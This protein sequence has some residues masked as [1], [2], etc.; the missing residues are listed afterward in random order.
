MIRSQYIKLVDTGSFPGGIHPVQHK[1]ESNSSPIATLPVPTTLW[2]P[3]AMHLG[4]P[5]EPIVQIGDRVF[6]GELIAAAKGLVSAN[7]H[8][9][10]SGTIQAIEPHAFA[11]ESGFAQ[12]AIAL[13]SDGLDQWRVLEPWPD[14]RSRG[15][16]PVLER[17]R[18][19]GV[20]GLGG[21]GFPT[22]VKYRNSQ[23]VIRTLLINAAECEPYITADDRLMRERADDILRGATICQWLLGAKTILIG[24]EDNKPEA[25]AAFRAAAEQLQVPIELAIV[26]TKYPSGGEKQ[27]IQLVLGVEVPHGGLPSDLGIVCQNVGTLAQIYRTVEL[28][29]PLISRVTTVTGAAVSHPGNYQVLIG[30]PI[31][32]LL[33][34]AGVQMPKADRVIMG[35]PMMGFVVP[36]LLAP[37]VKSTNCLLVPTKKEL[38]PALPDNPCIRCGLCEQACPVS[39]LPQQML[40]SAKNRQLDAALLHS[41]DDCIECGACAYVCPSRIP[42]VQYYRYA[43]GEIRQENEENVSAERARVRF[44]NRQKRLDQEQAEKEAKRQLRAEV[45]AKALA[46]KT[47]AEGQ[48][49]SETNELISA[50]LERVAAKKLAANQAPASMSLSD[51]AAA[52]Q[53]SQEK[54]AKAAARL[55]E[56]EINAPDMVPALKKATGKLEEKYL[57]TEAAYQTA[58]T[59]AEV[60]A[61]QGPN[62]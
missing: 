32:V 30:T 44:E 29:E 4:T 45:A 37:V 43:K 62:S 59:A 48:A 2:L 31:E 53:A 42:L 14:W 1:A 28:D 38:P 23:A 17:I 5:A 56:A 22:D 40:W 13:D 35:G 47:A 27:L 58:L 16:E 10:T 25:I 26:P 50:T 54:F 61:A 57:S 3:L 55:A 12:P 8:A 41:L 11:H 19:G 9:P 20:T 18:L 21:A 34:H 39:L 36:D 15:I 7:I 46:A 33:A 6:K 24:I 60:V 52:A 51:L 49:G